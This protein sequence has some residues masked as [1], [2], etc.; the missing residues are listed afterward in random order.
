MDIGLRYAGDPHAFWTWDPE[1]Q[2]DAL[3]HGLL[4]HQPV[5]KANAAAARGILDWAMGGGG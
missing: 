4:A 5:K 1:R 3:A 2:R